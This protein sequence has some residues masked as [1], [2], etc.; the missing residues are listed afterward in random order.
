MKKLFSG[1]SSRAKVWLAMLVATPLIVVL[2][3]I[4]LCI[5]PEPLSPSEILAKN[6]WTD[7]EL[8]DTLAR[9]ISPTMTSHQKG[10]VLRHLRTQLEQRTPQQRRNIRKAAVVATVMDTLGYLRK[11]P[12]N[13][14][15]VL[16]D[17]MHDKAE[18]N[19]KNLMSDNKARAQLSQAMHEAELEAF[20]NEV[21]R[22]IFSE[23]SP[24]E[25]VQFS[26]MIKVWTRTMK[27]LE[28]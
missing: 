15:Q 8:Q 1:R 21:N 6:N 16:L 7:A 4:V 13:Q 3:I 25:R 20:T 24:E 22:V 27:A 12:N 28:H 26:P 11:M 5:E 2:I 14:R 23:L 10:E 9:F 18:E 17:N 19:Y